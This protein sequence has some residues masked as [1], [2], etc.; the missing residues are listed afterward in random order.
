MT[1]L[2]S[3]GSR[4]DPSGGGVMTSDE[5][6]VLRDLAF[7]SLNDTSGDSTVEPFDPSILGPDLGELVYDQTLSGVGPDLITFL[8][9]AA[10]NVVI[11]GV[12]SATVGSH[13]G[14]TGLGDTAPQPVGS[15]L[16]IYDTTSCGGR[17]AFVFDAA[18]N[19]IPDPPF[20]I[21]AHEL[22]HAKDIITGTITNA[23]LETVAE[24]LATVVENQIRAEANP[25]Y[26]QAIGQSISLS[27]R[28]PTDHD[29]GC[30]PTSP[31][32]PPGSDPWK[33]NCFIASAAYGSDNAQKVSRL[34]Q[35]RDE[36]ICC[37]NLGRLFLSAFYSEY[38][39]YSQPIAKIM[40]ASSDQR[41]MVRQFIV[42][43]FIEFLE[44]VEI[45]ITNLEGYEHFQASVARVL[46]CEQASRSLREAE[47]VLSELRSA[48]AMLE[49]G[50]WREQPEGPARWP[51]NSVPA[52]I[53]FL[54]RSML[55]EARTT[56]YSRWALLEPLFIH[57]SAIQGHAGGSDLGSLVE[58]YEDLINAWLDRMPL[59]SGIRR[60]SKHE[61]AIDLSRFRHLVLREER[62]RR[63]IG[64]RLRRELAGQTDHDVSLLLHEAGFLPDLS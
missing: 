46:A 30:N 58:A 45:Y 53:G 38:Y 40:R 29:G 17:G 10:V 42:D 24:Q 20:I 61:L 39:R 27:Q 25:L 13:G 4:A 63:V 56:E 19:K 55:K 47:G 32:P 33:I 22:A 59:P 12:D 64:L 44:L 2:I 48:R 34:R 31:T 14:P 37:T 49:G 11:F 57:W 43:P 6:A 60:L 9:N 8:V 18:K 62:A 26:E 1:L 21:L 15:I 28:N 7:I 51:A 41:A 50:S 35:F 54:A 36:Y 16:I 3:S 5:T 23:T 52:I